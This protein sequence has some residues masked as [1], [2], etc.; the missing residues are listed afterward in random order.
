MFEVGG[1]GAARPSAKLA[2]ARPT[3][4]LSTSSALILLWL[5]LAAAGQGG[6]EAAEPNAGAVRASSIRIFGGLRWL[7]GGDVNDGVALWSQT[8]ESLLHNEVVGLQAGD[9][10]EVAALRQGGEFGVDVIVHRTSRVAIVG[11]VG[12]IESS[13]AGTI[14]NAVVYSRF[15]GV[16]RNST[17]LRARAILVR[18][19][20]QYSI[21]LGQRV[22]LSVEGGTGIYFT[23]LSWSHHLDV[24][25]GTSNW[26]SEMRGRD[27][28]LHGGVWVDLGLSERLGFVVGLHGVYANIAGLDGFREG[29]FSYRVPGRDDGTLRLADTTWGAQFLVVGDGSWLDDRYG[30]ITPAREASV[31]LGGLRLSAGL[32]MGL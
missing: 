27:V 31:G 21:P 2:A 23:D 8:F 14:E 11:G 30:P 5:P 19:A 16:T 6:S 18:L 4:G 7:G 3:D 25:G 15:R 29:T 22:S 1:G 20:A 17:N 13:S 24:N 10:G 9:G 32:R 26:V 28:G 12:V